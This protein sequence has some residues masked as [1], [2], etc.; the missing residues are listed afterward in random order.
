VTRRLTESGIRFCAV[1]STEHVAETYSLGWDAVKDL[2]KSA[3]ERRLE[4][5]DLSGV[6]R[7]AE[8]AIQKGHRYGGRLQLSGKD[9]H[10]DEALLRTRDLGVVEPDHGSALRPRGDHWIGE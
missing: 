5:A 6:T 10:P 8:F 1:A 4:P 2:H 3:L 7:L 9:R